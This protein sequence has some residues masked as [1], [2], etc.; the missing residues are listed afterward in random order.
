MG[1]SGRRDGKKE[2]VLTSSKEKLRELSAQGS[3]RPVRA[4]VRAS[5][6]WCS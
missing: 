6:A 3:L 4:R 5:E 2:G 1:G